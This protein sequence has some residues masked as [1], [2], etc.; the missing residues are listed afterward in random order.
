M[1]KHKIIKGHTRASAKVKEKHKQ[2][3]A[4]TIHIY[5][6]LSTSNKDLIPSQ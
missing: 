1:K 6:Y 5:T 4:N 2:F 3:K